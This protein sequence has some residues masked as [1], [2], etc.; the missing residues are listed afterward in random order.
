[1]LWKQKTYTLFLNFK[2]TAQFIIKYV[3]KL[4]QPTTSSL[5]CVGY[6]VI[7][8]V[9]FSTFNCLKFEHISDR[10]IVKFVSWYWNRLFYNA[11]I[12]ITRNCQRTSRKMS[13][14]VGRADVSPSRRVGK[15]ATSHEYLVRN[16]LMSTRLYWQLPRSSLVSLSKTADGIWLKALR[17]PHIL[18][19]PRVKDKIL[20]PI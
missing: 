9:Y 18:D 10:L 16:I 3:T 17:G 20:D 7:N 8:N 1:M 12:D 19:W 11:R 13:T 5:A 4:G 2:L 15:H 6:K 14:I